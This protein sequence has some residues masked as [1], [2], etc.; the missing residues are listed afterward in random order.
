MRVDNFA[1]MAP[2]TIIKA[3]AVKQVLAFE[4]LPPLDSLAL[5][6]YD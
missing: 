3:L 2:E 1:S 6:T 4:V 5:K